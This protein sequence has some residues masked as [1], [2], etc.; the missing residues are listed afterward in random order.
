MDIAIAEIPGT[1]TAPARHLCVLD[2]EGG[3]NA[4]AAASRVVNVL[5]AL[6]GSSLVF[7]TGGRASEA[8]LQTLAEQ[9]LPRLSTF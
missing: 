4:F 6:V 5:A 9:L 8:A 1:D 7:V 2:C 3:D